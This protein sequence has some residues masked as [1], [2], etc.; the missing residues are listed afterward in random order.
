MAFETL[1]LDTGTNVAVLTL[2]QPDSLN[3]VSQTMIDELTAA[4]EQVSQEN[5]GVRCL[6]MT[7]AGRAFCAGANLADGRMAGNMAN[8]ERDLGELLENGYHPILRKLR[9]LPFPFVTAVNGGAAGIGMSFALMGDLILV[10]RSAYFLQAFRRIGLVPDGGS[11]WL[12]PRLVGRARALELSMLGEKLPA[13]KALEWG[14][15]NRLYDD[16]ILMDETMIL[17]R[18][19]ADGP[20]QA[21][22]LI[23]HAYWQSFENSYEDQLG[24]ER[25][26]QR[27]AG[28]TKDFVEGVSAFI[29]KRNPDFT[30]D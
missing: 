20:T 14:L 18:S 23:R 7:G 24:L 19:L 11:T 4:L 2:N 28:R 22:K 6:V 1:S 9:D 27:R 10:A 3:A 5:S 8:P 15:I 25:D 30:G 29:Q 16:D 21:M 17:A 26:L 12:L 13:E